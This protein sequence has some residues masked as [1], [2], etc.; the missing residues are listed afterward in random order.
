MTVKELMDFLS[1]KLAKGQIHDDDVIELRQYDTDFCFTITS[2]DANSQF[3]YYWSIEF[4]KK[5][6]NKN[7][8]K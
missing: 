3:R 7:Q 5:S 2:T 6:N 1:E 4:N 8:T